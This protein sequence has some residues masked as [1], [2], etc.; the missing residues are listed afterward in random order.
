MKCKFNMS[1]SNTAL[2]CREYFF[3][4]VCFKTISLAYSSA[5]QVVNLAVLPATLSSQTIIKQVD[6]SQVTGS[7]MDSVVEKFSNTRF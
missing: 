3:H 7:S 6:S 1:S 5:W 2:L 4:L